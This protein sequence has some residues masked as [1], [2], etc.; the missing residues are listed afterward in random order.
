VPTRAVQPQNQ[1]ILNPNML[2]HHC[3]RFT[4]SSAARLQVF[5]CSFSTPRNAHATFSSVLMRLLPAPFTK[6]L[7]PVAHH[8]IVHPNRNVRRSSVPCRFLFSSGRTSPPPR[9][10]T[11]ISKLTVTSL[12][13]LFNS[14][15]CP[16]VVG[17]VTLVELKSDLCITMP[18]FSKIAWWFMCT[19]AGNLPKW[20]QFRR[21][22]G[23][24][25]GST[26]SP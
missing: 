6:S 18:N 8:G 10:K 1:S 23:C 11:T 7:K 3:K 20:N 22:G 25:C 4:N 17:E 16:I 26:S 5:V 13:S 21:H 2:Q 15:S 14:I 9:H 19:F 24:S 12:I